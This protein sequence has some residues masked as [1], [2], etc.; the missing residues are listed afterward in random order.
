MPTV[1]SIPTGPA[2]A[3]AVGFQP[4]QAPRNVV[5]NPNPTPGVA[6][7]GGNDAAGL[8]D[9]GAGAINAGQ[10][11]M[12]IASW[13]SFQD[14]TR[15]AKDADVA[16]GKARLGIL[17]GDGTAND[18]GLAG[19]SGQGYLDAYQPALDK[20]K[21][22]RTD[23]MTGIDDERA[24][25]MF[26]DIANRSDATTYERLAAQ[27]VAHRTQADL[28]TSEARRGMAINEATA[29]PGD[30]AVLEQSA[31]KIR[32][33]VMA[34]GQLRGDSPE[35]I[36]INTTKE[37]SRMYADN[38]RVLA[39]S[40]V[41]SAVALFDKVKG[42]LD[43]T[44]RVGL[45]EHLKPKIVASK[46][47]AIV[48]GVW[49]EA[50]GGV[51][52][53]KGVA[54][55]SLPHEQQAFLNT[56][57]GPES[58]G[59]YNVRYTP[60]GGV[61]FDGYAQ[62]P[63]IREKTGD[64]TSDAAGRYQFLSSTYKPIAG[65]LGLLDFS[66][67]SQDKAAM[68]LATTTYASNSGGRD[69]KADLKEGGHGVEIANALREVWPSLKA[70]GATMRFASGLTRPVPEGQ[71]PSEIPRPDRAALTDKVMAATQNDPEIQSA[72]LS[73]LANK[74][75]LYDM[76]NENERTT[77]LKTS[78]DLK[79]QLQAG[80]DSVP[81]P[82][83][84]IRHLLPAAAANDL[85][86]SLSEA[87]KSGQVFT[88]LQFASPAEIADQRAQLAAGIGPMSD[89]AQL[90]RGRVAGQEGGM[91]IPADGT[92]AFG[93]GQLNPHFAEQQADLK[94]F[95][96]AV[97][98]R[99]EMLAKDPVS[100]ASLTPDVK[101]ANAKIDPKVPQTLQDA[102][103]ANRAAQ[104]RLGVPADDVRTMTNAQIAGVVSTLHN[105]D[106][107]AGDLTKG[108]A[109]LQKQYGDSWG[110]AFRD[111]VKVGKLDPSYQMLGLLSG[112]AQA[113]VGAEYT[114]AL[115]M[116]TQ[117][118]HKFDE[119]PAPVK[120]PYEAT[121]QSVFDNFRPTTAYGGET[122]MKNVVEPA[123]DTLAKYYVMQ[124][125]KPDTA[126]SNAYQKLIGDRYDVSGT[127]RSPK[128]L[129]VKAEAMGS[130]ILGSL[131][132]ERLGQP[133]GNLDFSN[134]YNTKLSAPD[135]AA[136]QSWVAT[137]P[138]GQRNTFDYDMRGA[139]KAGAGAAGNGH[140]PDTFKKPNHPTFSD[141]SQYNGVDGYRGG[142]WEGEDGG[143]FTFKTGSANTQMRSPQELKDYFSR[144]EPGNKLVLSSSPGSP[145]LA[146]A[147]RGSWIA[148]PNDTGMMLIAP[149]QGV[150]V[151]VMDR[152]GKPIAASWKDVDAHKPVA[153]STVGGLVTGVPF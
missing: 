125:Q 29:A 98:K 129:M 118:G 23:I 108:M 91:A 32:G 124:G 11:T 34:S 81:I 55:T 61:T 79:A 96:E 97:A 121:M 7:F 8:Q 4:V 22:A 80:D 44:V 26:G 58:A 153:T 42:G 95:D 60:N 72:A 92:P 77:L 93:S 5:T 28:A 86:G 82:E 30:L 112:Q 100:F 117:L 126:V 9:F 139:F 52:N 68:D 114:R 134:R 143:P 59:K 6:A 94:R 132:P 146:E 73:R 105:V 2:V 47:T 122:M 24:K 119:M 14:S 27:N 151:P 15:K 67:V 87:K 65:K 123:V 102:V 142:S 13:M 45:E 20:L 51:S 149:K 104:L 120:Q 31:A 64:S 50:S 35:V 113:G 141:Q 84:K 12:K 19:K 88:G 136:Y 135:E 90:H 133:G 21:Q 145:T 150:M 70:N 116:R 103:A 18:T 36:Q 106:P 16:Y 131:T 66:P 17:Y 39:D 49:A 147:Q 37:L 148:T 99:N 85:I 127:L 25:G 43:A 62:H 109:D 69:L 54:D 76:H 3:P 75:S 111:L 138:E 40:N 137:L 115:Q 140:F 83:D 152:T 38:I 56:L 10:D 53:G 89:N 107:N 1:P 128:G 71:S 57:A 74:F 63:Q 48:E 101:A 144:V 33:E 130:E 46:A 41:P 78:N 110:G